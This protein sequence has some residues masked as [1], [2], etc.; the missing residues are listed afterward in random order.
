MPRTKLDKKKNEA[1]SVLV[2][3]YI[4]MNNGTAKEAAERLQRDYRT[5]CRRL[6]NPGNFTIDELLDL[7]RKLH[8]PIDELRAAIRY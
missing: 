1:L 4:Y 5:L 8:I 3:G 7:G 6:E 2:N